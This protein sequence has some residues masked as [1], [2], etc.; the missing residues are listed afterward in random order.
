MVMRCK[1]EERVIERCLKGI[2]EQKG[3]FSLEVI[4]VDSGSTDRTLEI[5]RKFPAKIILM[6]P[7]E[8]TFG[9]ACNVAVNSSSG[10]FVAFI[11]AHSYPGTRAWLELLSR[12]LLQD[13]HVVAAAGYNSCLEP[14]TT[15]M[16]ACRGFY[17]QHV[18]VQH[19]LSLE[20]PFISNSNAMYR[21]DYLLRNPFNA[22]V[23]GAED[24]LWLIRVLQS[25]KAARI[26]SVPTAVCHHYHEPSVND[27]FYRMRIHGELHRLENMPP[28]LSTQA[29]LRI[30]L[31]LALRYYKYLWQHRM[32]YSK[33]W[34]LKIG[35]YS[36]SEIAGYLTGR[37]GLR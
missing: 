1:N 27:N 37:F 2:Y 30:I 28:L 20:E 31:G 6:A 23:S 7:Q 9:R 13:P 12:P 33:A 19:D 24:V 29:W 32:D 16:A 4:V 15:P 3:K 8:F 26:V 5:C 21:R 25:D 11:S 18:P 14:L 10:D 17:V 22:A 34:F 36:L 35:I